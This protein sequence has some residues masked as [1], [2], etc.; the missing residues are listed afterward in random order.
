ML[1]VSLEML[2]CCGHLG[3]SCGDLPVSSESETLRRVCSAASTGV[4]EEENGKA[5]FRL[6]IDRPRCNA[7]RDVVCGSSNGGMV[8]SWFGK[9]DRCSVG[10]LHS[11]GVLLSQ[12]SGDK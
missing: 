11:F 9:C 10:G 7:Y 5:S 4:A 8:E 6:G 12:M 3:M 1:S 2:L